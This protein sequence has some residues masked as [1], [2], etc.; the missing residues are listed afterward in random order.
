MPPSPRR[1][2]LGID[3]AP[4]AKGRDPVVPIVGVLMEGAD[5]VEAVAIAS[6]PV[7][8][9]NATDF[10]ARWITGLRVRPSVQAVVLGGITIAG[11]GLVDLI[12]LAEIIRRPV[13]AVT[14]RDPSNSELRRALIAAGLDERLPL[15]E[16]IPPAREIREGL[17]VAAAGVSPNEVPKLAL[18]TLGKSNLPESL[19][20]AHLIARALTM[21]ESRGRV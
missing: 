14:R 17:F 13:L 15:L 11:L 6:F 18:A 12:G 10:L 5:L 21:G 3:D 9:S 20:V 8:G 1:H 19:R 7:D 4:F 2:I 16:R